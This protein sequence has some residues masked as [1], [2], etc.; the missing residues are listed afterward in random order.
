[1]IPP[2]YNYK[3]LYL[4]LQKLF[5]QLLIWKVIR[6]TKNELPGVLGD[7]MYVI[8]QA[9]RAATQSSSSM[10]GAQDLR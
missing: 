6:S 1:M 4:F 3:A 9:L 8:L 7:E 5:I 10:L 2:K